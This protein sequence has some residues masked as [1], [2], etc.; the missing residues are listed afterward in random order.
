MERKGAKGGFPIRELKRKGKENGKK[1]A[2]AH[3]ALHLNP[4]PVGL[5]NGSSDG[6]AQSRPAF[7]LGPR[8]CSPVEAPEDLFLIFLGDAD[9]RVRNLQDSE[10]FISAEG[11]FYASPRL[12]VFDPII[13][14]V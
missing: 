6:Q 5:D 14:Q 10:F 9:P 7:T 1:A 11:D 2:F 3:G 4:S 13:H 12:R 8:R